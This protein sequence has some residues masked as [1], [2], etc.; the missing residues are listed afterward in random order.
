VTGPIS[1]PFAVE[2]ANELALAV[3][4]LDSAGE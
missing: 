4:Y 3:I 1:P 2:G